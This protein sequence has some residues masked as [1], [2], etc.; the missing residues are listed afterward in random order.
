MNLLLLILLLIHINALN[1][2]I[3]LMTLFKGGGGGDGDA[4]SI[5]IVNVCLYIF[6]LYMVISYLLLLF[7]IQNINT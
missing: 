4:F 1:E 2:K 6:T 7:S 3:I 5:E